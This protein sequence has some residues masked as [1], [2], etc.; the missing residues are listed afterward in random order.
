MY[1]IKD[2][3]PNDIKKLI[4]WAN[5]IILEHN[6]VPMMEDETRE[7]RFLEL[8]KTKKEWLATDLLE[9]CKVRN[10][11]KSPNL[12]RTLISYQLL[13]GTIIETKKGRKTIVSIIIQ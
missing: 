1:E 5:T 11:C 10:I 6:R 9:E 12:Y 4:R 3:Y 13:K 7:L 2:E 8:V